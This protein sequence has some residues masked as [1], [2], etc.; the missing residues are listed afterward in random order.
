[1]ADRLELLF[2]A[3]VRELRLARGFTQEELAERAYIHRTYLASIEKGRRNVAI[4]NVI[5]LSR[6]LGVIPGDLFAAFTPD[7]LRELPPNARN[8]TRARREK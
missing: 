8:L 1:M 7:A 2:G 6:A 3:R 4:V 5:Y